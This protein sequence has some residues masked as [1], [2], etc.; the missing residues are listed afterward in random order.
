MSAYLK[1]VVSEGEDDDKDFEDGPGKS[2]AYKVLGSGVLQVLRLV[3]SRWQVIFEYAPSGWKRVDGTRFNDSTE[4]LAG[5]HG[6]VSKGIVI[7]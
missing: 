1:L 6:E 5:P 7:D 3:E 4:S 2:Y